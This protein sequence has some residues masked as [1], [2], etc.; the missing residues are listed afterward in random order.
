MKT[1]F[2]E[3]KFKKTLVQQKLVRLFTSFYA[4]DSKVH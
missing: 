3:K 1:A 2:Y 4:V